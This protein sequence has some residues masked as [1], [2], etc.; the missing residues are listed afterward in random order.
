MSIPKAESFNRLKADYMNK[1]ERKNPGIRERTLGLWREVTRCSSFSKDV[2]IKHDEYPQTYLKASD[3]TRHS[4]CPLDEHG[5]IM[6]PQ[7]QTLYDKAMEILEQDEQW[8]GKIKRWYFK[9][10][11]P[12]YVKKDTLKSCTCKHHNQMTNLLEDLSECDLWETAH[13]DCGKV[14]EDGKPMGCQCG[15]LSTRGDCKNIFKDK[16]LFMSYMV[17]TVTVEP[18]DGGGS[19]RSECKGTACA[20]S[21]RK[22]CGWGT[23]ASPTTPAVCAC[24][25]MDKALDTMRSGNHDD[26]GADGS[27]LDS[28]ISIR[29]Y[30]KKAQQQGADGDREE[31]WDAAEVGGNVGGKQ[32]TIEPEMLEAVT[33][34]WA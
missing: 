27:S 32:A 33:M 20:T 25:T 34:T 31:R 22:D 15:P 19:A 23:K 7:E 12:W 9:A 10:C 30:A 11:K 4:E 24:A 21:D 2:Q 5:N 6:C 1:T 18:G 26:P 13:A 3:G 29:R 17:C 8:R 16:R 28:T 14:D